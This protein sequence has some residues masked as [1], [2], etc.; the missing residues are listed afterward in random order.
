MMEA[1]DF[2]VLKVDI[3]FL[4]FFEV[5]FLEFFKKMTQLTIEPLYAACIHEI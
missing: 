3:K 1:D 4:N 5:I 2:L